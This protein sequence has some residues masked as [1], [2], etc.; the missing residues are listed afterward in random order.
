MFRNRKWWNWKNIPLWQTIPFDIAHINGEK[1]RK[2]WYFFNKRTNDFGKTNSNELCF[3]DCNFL[4]N[5]NEEYMF[6]FIETILGC[7]NNDNEYVF[8]VDDKEKQQQIQLIIDKIML[9][10]NSI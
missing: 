3:I 6:I 5:K 4:A 8:F 2:R 9:S 10:Q 7:C 1:T